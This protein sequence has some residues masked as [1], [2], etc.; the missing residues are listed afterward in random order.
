LAS[1]PSTPGGPVSSATEP[2]LISVAA[3]RSNGSRVTGYVRK[4]QLDRV[5]GADVSS[6]HAA[7]ASTRKHKAPQTIPVY[8]VD[9]TT[10]IGTFTTSP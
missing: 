1:T 8:R 5:T 9:G 4:S 10:R 7:I 6:L 3:R 2:D